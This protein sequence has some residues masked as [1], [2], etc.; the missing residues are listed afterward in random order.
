MNT[1]KFDCIVIGAGAA[2]LF[3]AKELAENG[4]QVA[5]IEAKERTGGRMLTV[6]EEGRKVEL[7][8]EFIHGDLALSKEL[9]QKAGAKLQPVAGGLWQCKDGELTPQEDFIEDYGDLEKKCRN[10]ETDK[11]VADFLNEGLQ[12]MKYEALRFS[13]KNYVEGYDA[14]DLEKASTRALCEDLQQD[15]EEQF[16]IEG[17]YQIL[18]DY[19]ECECRSLG[20]LFF[21]SQPVLQLYWKKGEVEA[22]TEK[23][24]YI[25]ARALLTVSLGVLQNGGIGFLPA[26][27]DV[28]ASAQK[29]GFG[30]VIK[31]VLQFDHPFWTVKEKMR[32]QDLRDLGF[33]FS[34]EE[35]PTWWTH[36]PQKVPVLT[37][38][39]GGPRAKAFQVL[40]KEELVEKALHS[41]SR[42]FRIQKEEL[43]QS[44]VAA[45]HYNWGDDPHFSGAYSFVAVGAEEAVATLKTPIE[46]TLFFAGEGLHLGPE[47]GTVEAALLSGQEAAKQLL[48]TLSR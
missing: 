32:E 8:A 27:P 45:S 31:L 34:E 14:A 46:D 19:L 47:A 37:G 1:E 17:G 21:L 12:G 35:I 10:L 16:R 48:A 26:L 11:P 3:A 7:G 40:R 15:D 5:V 20:V 39:I 43:E 33:L 18:V 36:F 44:L 42:I 23:G 4:W 2:G 22:V 29:L 13:L 6:S 38:W 30:Q 9:L 24:T 28:Q 41:L 25:A